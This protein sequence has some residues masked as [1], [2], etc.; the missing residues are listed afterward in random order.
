[1]SD[2]EGGYI[3]PEPLATRLIQRAEREIGHFPSRPIGR[4]CDYCGR[5]NDASRHT[6]EG[7]QAP[8]PQ[9]YT[10]RRCPPALPINE[11]FKK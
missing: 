10:V 2:N 4:V 6:C 1:M 9:Y 5:V 7:C 11:G 8:F 3:L